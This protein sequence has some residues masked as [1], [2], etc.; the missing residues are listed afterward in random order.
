MNS[1]RKILLWGVV[2][3]L[4]PIAINLANAFPDSTNRCGKVLHT[5]KNKF[6]Y[7]FLIRGFVQSYVSL[8]LA[9]VLNA[10]TVR[11]RLPDWL[12]SSGRIARRS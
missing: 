11:L 4:Y 1:G 2:I 5:V 8:F 9:C 7:Q 12:S 6:Q 10:Y 3:V